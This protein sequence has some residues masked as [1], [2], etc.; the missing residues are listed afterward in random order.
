M[1]PGPTAKHFL[2]LTLAT[3]VALWI[4]WPTEEE[5]AERRRREYWQEIFGQT[6]PEPLPPWP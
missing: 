1:G 2:V 5:R 3:L 6:P 4:V